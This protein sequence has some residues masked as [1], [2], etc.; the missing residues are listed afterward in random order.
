L[1]DPGVIC[2]EGPGSATAQLRRESLSP[3]RTGNQNGN[4]NWRTFLILLWLAAYGL[5]A[6]VA[7]QRADGRQWD[8]CAM[9]ACGG[10]LGTVGLASGWAAFGRS[11]LPGRVCLLF[12]VDLIFSWVLHVR[13][14]FDLAGY[15]A[16]L[17]SESIAIVV[18]SI[19]L[20]R[21]GLRLH[22]PVAAAEI[23]AGCPLKRSQFSL[24]TLLA[25]V[26]GIAAML[27]ILRWLS[28]FGN[29]YIVTVVIGGVFGGVGFVAMTL[30]LVRG[31]A[32]LRS[33]AG[34]IALGAI[35]AG[36]WF[37]GVRLIDLRVVSAN[38]LAIMA[39]V[40]SSLA[41]FRVCGYRLERVPAA[42][43]RPGVRDG[44]AEEPASPAT[45]AESRL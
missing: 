5:V 40:G 29:N 27:G 8:I 18:G 30:T 13:W 15:M 7:Y 43:R 12:V 45:A 28:S 37:G 41:V 35:L 17:A 14:P 33:V 19:F 38:S 39:S 24:T 32:L 31:F 23:I 16:L 25:S 4:M 2:K 44:S 10:I 20:R 6:T 34:A 3:A 42:R 1:V 21:H 9:V 36:F 26:S 22:V 11:P